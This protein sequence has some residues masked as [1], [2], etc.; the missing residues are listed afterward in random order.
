MT[1][2]LTY[3]DVSWVRPCWGTKASFKAWLCFL[4]FIGLVPVVVELL[5]TRLLLLLA[6]A[7]LPS[8]FF[9]SSSFSRLSVSSNHGVMAAKCFALLLCRWRRSCALHHF[10]K[11]VDVYIDRFLASSSFP[12]CR[13]AKQYALS[14]MTEYSSHGNRSY[15]LAQNDRAY[16]PTPNTVLGKLFIR[17]WDGPS[18]T[19]WE[20]SAG[21]I[22]SIGSFYKKTSKTLISLH[23]VTWDRSRSNQ[24]KM[25]SLWLLSV[26]NNKLLTQFQKSKF[27]NTRAKLSFFAI[28]I[29][30][31]IW[32]KWNLTYTGYRYTGFINSVNKI[33]FFIIS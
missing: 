5:P 27:F 1:A 15:Q 26:C 16:L 14:M 11:P 24:I 33:I 28:P 4:R 23:Q 7:A 3:H 32:Y 2:T 19:L 21:M 12:K 30:K 6:C 10:P 13:Q 9:I 18:S 20:M 31:A 8:L 29:S 25:Q 22:Q 17:G